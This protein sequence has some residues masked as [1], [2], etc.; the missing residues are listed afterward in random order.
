MSRLQKG[1]A[2]AI[3]DSLLDAAR[4]G[5]ERWSSVLLLKGAPSLVASPGGGQVR[6]STTGSSDLARAGMGD[7]L[8][9][10][11]V[12]FM[13]RGLHA[14]D[15]ASLA[16]HYSGRAAA[17]TGKGEGLLPSDI[18]ESLGAALGEPPE[19]SDLELPFITLDLDPPH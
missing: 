4:I 6:V 13:A 16:L 17:F 12:A 2:T 5:A 15:A 18:A 7:V 3:P 9:G 14:A 1:G 11:A 19:E 8:G 10:V